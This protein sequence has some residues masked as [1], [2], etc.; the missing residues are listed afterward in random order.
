M[1]VYG[2]RIDGLINNYSKVTMIMEYPLLSL[3]REFNHRLL[4]KTDFAT[5]EIADVV[6]SSIK[7]YA[8]LEKA[9]CSNDKVRMAHI[10]VGV[11][12][13]TKESKVKVIDSDLLMTPSNYQAMLLKGAQAP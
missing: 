6:F 7:A 3:K 13:R 1:E 4:N 12:S 9:G 2:K 5:T 11:E 8:F 10:V